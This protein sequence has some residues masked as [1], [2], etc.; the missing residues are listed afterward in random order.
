[1]DATKVALLVSGETAFGETL[2]VF[3]FD[4]CSYFHT[5]LKFPVDK[6]LSPEKESHERLDFCWSNNRWFLSVW[7]MLLFKKGK[8]SSE[9]LVS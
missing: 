1:M 9:T 4:M 6:E 7:S 5:G 3:E 8:L 2:T